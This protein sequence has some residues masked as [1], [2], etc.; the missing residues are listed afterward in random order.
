[1]S[2]V[3]ELQKEALSK[4]V[5]ILR[6]L[7]KAYLVARKLRLKDFEEWVNHELNGYGVNDK[8]PDY[9]IY[10]GVVK[11]WNPYNGWISVQFSSPNR[12]SVHEAREPIASLLDVYQNTTDH[13]ATVPFNDAINAEL[14]KQSPYP[15]RYCL[16]IATNLLYSTFD[17]LR[18]TILDWALTLEE[19]GIVGDEISFSLDEIQTA[20]N[21]PVINNYTNNF[22]GGA[23]DTQI[24]Q[25]ERGVFEKKLG[26]GK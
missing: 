24:Q 23:G 18:N 10:T 19:N 16:Q 3:I 25:G 4:D 13:I 6:L 1:M 12:L 8:L 20:A 15:T 5:D 21:T 14:S 17:R 9:R 26:S 2:I 11:A 7:R 22:Y